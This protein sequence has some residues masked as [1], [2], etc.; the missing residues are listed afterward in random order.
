MYIIHSCPLFAAINWRHTHTT[1][2][3]LTFRMQTAFIK[4]AIC[5][6]TQ[7]IKY[8]FN[9]PL[10]AVNYIERV[11]E[12]RRRSQK[13]QAAQWGCLT[14]IEKQLPRYIHCRHTQCECTWRARCVFVRLQNEKAR[15]KRGLSEIYTAGIA[16]NIYKVSWRQKGSRGPSIDSW[17]LQPH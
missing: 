8:R 3:I 9:W 16:R 10:G 4:G 15:T 6:H 14:P 12:C 5:A 7:I 13:H 17:L 1:Y 2:I 11:S